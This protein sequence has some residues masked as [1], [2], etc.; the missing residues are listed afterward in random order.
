MNGNRLRVIPLPVNPVAQLRKF[1]VGKRVAKELLKPVFA[2]QKWQGEAATVGVKQAI[3]AELEKQQ[4][5]LDE[6]RKRINELDDTQSTELALNWRQDCLQLVPGTEL[7]DSVFRHYGARF[8]KETDSSHIAA[9][10][11]SGEINSE[12]TT[13]IQSIVK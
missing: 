10:R 3:L 8:R 7:L 5:A 13:L 1:T 11:N 4:N 6:R 12:L 2:T 9:A